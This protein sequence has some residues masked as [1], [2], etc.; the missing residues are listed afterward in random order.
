MFGG[1][2]SQD[3]IAEKLFFIFLGIQIFMGLGLSGKREIFIHFMIP[4]SLFAIWVYFVNGFSNIAI[5]Y[6]C[7]FVIALRHILIKKPI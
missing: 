2:L 3:D 4:F 5:F 1:A 6:V 7:L